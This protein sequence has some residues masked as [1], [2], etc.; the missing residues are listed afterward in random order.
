MP[1]SGNDTI[2]QLQES[3]VFWRVVKGGPGLPR[4]GGPSIS[5]MPSWE[6]SLTEEEVWKVILFIYDY[7]GNTPR[8]WK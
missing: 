8:S 1:F 2:A 4:E 3:Y 7:T 6:A 5:S